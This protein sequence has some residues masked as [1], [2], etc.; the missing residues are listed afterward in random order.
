MTYKKCKKGKTLKKAKNEF[1]RKTR[2]FDLVRKEHHNDL[3]LF[4]E[5]I[6]SWLIDKDTVSWNTLNNLNIDKSLI[7]NTKF[8]LHVANFLHR[9]DCSNGLKCRMAV[10]IRYIASSE[11][12]N[13]CLKE[14]TVKVKIYRMLDY[15]RS[16][17]KNR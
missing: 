9:I 6:R 3:R 11:H 8:L 15:F 2:L 13:F 16:K 14:S 1:T 7:P 5:E 10:F 17:A 12:S 4:V